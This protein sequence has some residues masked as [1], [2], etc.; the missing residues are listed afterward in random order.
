MTYLIHSSSNI[1][2]LLYPSLHIYLYDSTA[3]YNI[4]NNSM[5][6]TVLCRIF[7]VHLSLQSTYM[8]HSKCNDLDGSEIHA[9]KEVA[10]FQN[11]LPSVYFQHSLLCS[12]L[13]TSSSIQ[14]PLYHQEEET[15]YDYKDEQLQQ[16]YDE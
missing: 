7:R 13:Y 11:S 2:W 10:T 16:P 6:L 1:V 15:S 4:A 8:D 5:F 12:T 3:T 14:I 9:Q